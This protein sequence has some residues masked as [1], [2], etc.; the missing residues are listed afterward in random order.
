MTSRPRFPAFALLAL[1]IPATLAAVTLNT[2]SN[3]QVA[4]AQ[5]MN[6]NF[7]ALEAEV[8]ALRAERASLTG[9]IAAFDGACPAGWTEFTA[10]R[11]R[12]LRGEPDANAASLDSGGSDDEI[13]VAHTHT[14]TGTAAS[15][16]AH[17]HRQTTSGGAGGNTGYAHVAGQFTGF[18]VGG[19][20]TW[21]TESNG[22]HTH[23]V[24]G[25]TDATGSAAAGRNMPA[26]REVVWCRKS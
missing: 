5:K 7:A 3:G 24:S 12:F 4:D 26:F 10:G 19:I 23:S 9:M 11:G 25:T 13:V 22:A 18:S 15:A 21:T 2:F 6:E 14:F 17:T 8:E 16:G 1:A 20:G